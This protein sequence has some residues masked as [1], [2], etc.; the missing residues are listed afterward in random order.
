[1]RQ[2]YI[3]AINET[4]KIAELCPI[5]LV[6]IVIN[7]SGY[8]MCSA[9]KSVWA[10]EAFSTPHR[11]ANAANVSRTK[12]GSFPITFCFCRLNMRI[13]LFSLWM[14]RIRFMTTLPLPFFPP[15]FIQELPHFTSHL[16][17][18]SKIRFHAWAATVVSVR[19]H[20]PWI[21]TPPRSRSPPF[22][23]AK[24]SPKRSFPSQNPAIPSC[25]AFFPPFF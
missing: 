3:Q 11:A 18:F 16:I 13:A 4:C 12:A 22:R 20:F 6:Q 9:N 2:R 10:N 24:P 14:I 19:K 25:R 5:H 23:T 15:L 21:P 7:G 17:H 8:V 1:M